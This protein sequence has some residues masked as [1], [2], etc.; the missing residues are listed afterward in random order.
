MLFNGRT[1]IFTF[2]RTQV[3]IAE[4]ER[5]QSLIKT[6]MACTYSTIAITHS[7]R[8]PS[9]L[10]RRPSLSLHPPPSIPLP[11][12]PPPSPPYPRPP[13]RPPPP[14]PPL[15]PIHSFLAGSNTRYCPPGRPPGRPPSPLALG[16]GSPSPPPPP[17]HP[18]PLSPPP[19]PSTPSTQTPPLHPLHPL[20]PPLP[21]PPPPGT[22][23]PPP[24]IFSTAVYHTLSERIWPPLGL[25]LCVTYVVSSQPLCAILYNY[26]F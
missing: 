1:L 21:A 12:P 6:S 13:R 8:P 17:L 2:S 10:H 25:R 20:H 14:P 23:P 19:L 22:P 11:P 9:P 7:A 3:R 4:H 16:L 26:K 15:P 5:L 18:P 24:P